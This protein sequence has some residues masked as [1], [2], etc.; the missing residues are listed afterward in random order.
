MIPKVSAA[1]RA[2][3]LEVARKVSDSFTT[4]SREI[5]RPSDFGR[6]VFEAVE[7]VCHGRPAKVA[8][9]A[10]LLGHDASTASDALRDLLMAVEEVQMHGVDTDD[11]WARVNHARTLVSVDV[12]H[13]DRPV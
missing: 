3:A 6:C 12:P 7:N 2:H 11:A 8:Y 1:F 5:G 4:G 13:R 9:L 10:Y